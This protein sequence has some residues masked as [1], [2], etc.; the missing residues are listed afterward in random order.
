MRNI[1]SIFLTCATMSL[2][3]QNEL[4]TGQ[5]EV[6]KDF[7]VRLTE[8]NKIRIVPQPIPVD[9]SVRRYEYKLLAPSPSIDYPSPEIKPLAINAEKK[10]LY[11]PL[12]AKVGYG[13]P[14]SLLGMFSYDHH[15]NENFQWGI[16]FRHLN[17]NNKKIPL[18][19]F[20]DSRGRINASYLMHENLLIEGFIDGHVEKDYFYGADPIPAN[21][22]SLK[23]VFNRYDAYVAI[24]KVDSVQY[25]LRYKAFMEYMTDKDDLGSREN[26]FRIG[27]EVGTNV[28]LNE[29]PIGIK[30]MADMSRL[31]HVDEH[32]VNNILINP[33]AD[34][35]FGLFKFHVGATA[36]LRPDQNEL[37]PDLKVTY[38]IAHSSLSIH[39]GWDGTV[40]KNNFHNLST[41]NP[42]IQTRLDSLNNQISRRLFLG[43]DGSSGSLAYELNAS[44]TSFETMAFFLQNEDNP[45]QFDAIYDS[46]SYIGIE[47]TLKYEILKHVLLRTQFYQRFY[48]LDNETK[49]WHRPSFGL[50]GQ[51]TYSGGN[52]KY[53]ASFIF[54]GENGLPYR[55]VGGTETSLDPLV[56]LNLHGDYY[57][58]KS[59]GAFVELNNLLGNH[60]ERWASYPSYGFNAKVGVL[61]RLP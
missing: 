2:I 40:V 41:Y 21:E 60:R 16:D 58:A 29:Y 5:I 57:F 19:K 48:S 15:Q 32:T 26:A 20:S 42:Y 1:L 47:A 23:R 39:A 31:T 49:P 56:D 43:L 54:N 10:P 12:Y 27:G 24:S 50:N 61:F 51:L 33:F 35:F 34:F 22:E 25:G 28:G 44:Y 59:F 30:L 3:A 55:T 9:S 45:E 8:T 11:Y 4:P 52:D 53:H 37:L 18:Q 13:S 38:A 36:L 14:N 46:G 7:E 17:A 6:I